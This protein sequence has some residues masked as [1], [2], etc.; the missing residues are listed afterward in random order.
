MRTRPVCRMKLST[1]DHLRTRFSTLMTQLTQHIHSL[2]SLHSNMAVAVDVATEHVMSHQ[3]DNMHEHAVITSPVTE[4]K[5]I[6]VMS[7]PSAWDST[8]VHVE[9]QALPLTHDIERSQQQSHAHTHVTPH[10]IMLRDVSQHHGMAYEEEQSVAEDGVTRRHAMRAVP[11]AS[12]QPQDM[13]FAS[14]LHG[15][16]MLTSHAVSHH[17][18]HISS[19]SHITS[20]E[21]PIHDMYA[22]ITHAQRDV[23]MTQQQQQSVMHTWQMMCDE[24]EKK[25]AVIRG[26]REEKQVRHSTNTARHADVIFPACDA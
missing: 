19:L 13:P 7:T 12:I 14:E 17:P 5:H 25:D 11:V 9:M 15:T 6:H 26:M 10:T 2:A 24:S 20:D 1:T 18:I 16:G 3:H 23:P 22:I 21:H 4:A 8:D